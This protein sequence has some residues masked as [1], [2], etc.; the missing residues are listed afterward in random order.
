[1]PLNVRVDGLASTT[2]VK[3]IRVLGLAALGLWTLPTWAQP[4]GPM[5]GGRPSQGG[6]GMGMMRS[7]KMRL[8]R[9]IESASRLSGS[10][11]LSKKQAQQM[12]RLV[13]PWRKKP[14]MS[15]D[16]GKNLFT[17]LSGTLNSA[18]KT[19]MQNDRPRMGDGR[20]PGGPNGRG[21]PQ[22]GGRG[23][24]GRG[25]GRGEGGPGGRPGGP[26]G[27]GGRGMQRPTEAQMKAMRSMMASY[28]PLYSG[29]PAGFASMPDQFKKGMQRRRD[30]LNAALSQ[31]QQKAR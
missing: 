23:P 18:Q 16:A 22:G 26:G 11:A 27:P 15:E 2:T 13:T 8:P 19:A 1:M 24:G 30:R 17:S 10:T 3:I 7:E 5:Q 12:V 28:N 4:G 25:G 31:I 21:G 14:I 29:N 9:F 20:G 6:R